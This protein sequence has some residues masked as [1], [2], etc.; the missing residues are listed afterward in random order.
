MQAKKTH[1]TIDPP[2]ADFYP[3]KAN[4]YEEMIKANSQLG[5]MFPYTHPGSILALLVFNRGDRRPGGRFEHNNTVDE[6]Y[7]CLGSSVG[8]MRPGQVF[9]STREHDV[10][11][12]DTQSTEDYFVVYYLQRQKD[13]GEHKEVMVFRCGKCNDALYRYQY[14]GNCANYFTAANRPLVPTIVG[15]ENW[16][17][18]LE[19][20]P[21]L[22]KCPKCG[23]QN[24]P[25]PRESWGWGQYLNNADLA[26]RAELAMARAASGEKA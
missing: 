8:W 4:I 19:K 25:F 26:A 11:G 23:H 24:E 14:D 22:L 18:H 15:A 5:P 20:H 1:L 9:V 13:H 12:M 16:A 21:E 6:I 17:L 7:C 3:R 2:A 10:Y